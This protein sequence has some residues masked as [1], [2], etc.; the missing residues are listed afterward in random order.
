M[1]RN[2]FQILMMA[3]ALVAVPMLLTGCGE[4]HA[5]SSASPA[6]VR[7]PA[8]SAPPAPIE[9]TAK[10]TPISSSEKKASAREVSLQGLVE[11][12]QAGKNSGHDGV[13]VSGKVAKTMMKVSTL[14]AMVTM[15]RMKNVGRLP[16]TLNRLVEV[17][18]V[19][20]TST[21]TDEWGNPITLDSK[22][23]R[24]GQA[25]DIYSSGPDGKAGTED[26][27]GNWTTP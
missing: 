21:F 18:M 20:D 17:G 14:D 23:T 24:S 11:A 19:T 2:R 25:C 4:K 8:E 27:I 26:D 12:S 3:T 5:N 15:Y 1:L 22:G 13:I 10:D 9:S 7:T 16:A 6:P